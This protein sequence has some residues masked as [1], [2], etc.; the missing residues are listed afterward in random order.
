MKE[1]ERMTGSSIDRR[2]FLQAAALAGPGA[3]LPGCDRHKNNNSLFSEKSATPPN[4]ILVMTDDQGWGETGYYHHPVLKTPNLD[5][6]AANGLRFDRFYA[7][8]PVCSPTRA[9]VLTGRAN[10]RTG[11]P[12]HAHYLRLQERTLPEALKG[13]GYATGHFGKWHLNGLRGPG[14]PIFADDDHGPAAFGFE[15]WL[16]VTNYFD[17][18][19]IM[20]DNG[21]FKAFSGD[22][23]SIIVEHA[24]E[25]IADCN[26]RQMPFFAVIWDGS[27]HRPCVASEADRKPFQ[28]L[29]S[30]SRHHY[31]ELVAFDRS[32]GVLRKALRQLGIADNTLIWYCSDNGGLS[33]ISP[34]TVG[35]LRGY[36]G[37]MWEGG[38]RVPAVI[39]WPSVLNPQITSFPAS[40]LDIFPTLAHILDLPKSVLLD[41]VDGISLLSLFHGN[42]VE[43]KTAIPFRYA[44]QGA[45]I[46]NDYKLVTRDIDNAKFQLYNLKRD[47]KERRDISKTHPT[48]FSK[49]KSAFGQWNNSVN[50]SIAG[51]D[52]PQGKVISQ[53]PKP[54]FWMDDARYKPFFDEWK[55]RPEYSSVLK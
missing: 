25:F 50:A 38:L 6:M 51:K 49:M 48:H 36:K 52:Y 55:K 27:P 32:I 53:K 54:H 46:D 2:T 8:A 44:N 37:S 31:G 10:D 39:E 24:L 5:A 20:S 12:F 41:P 29:D 45:L 15:R 35:G 1:R 16:S 28:D 30:K 19:P 14:V 21:T 17:M 4:I 26:S 42:S 7:G 22:T 11:V 43:R 18:N 23:S 47:P 33:R 34:D 13:A 9:T 40:T 3:L